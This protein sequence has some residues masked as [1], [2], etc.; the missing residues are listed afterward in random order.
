[1]HDITGD[2]AVYSKG[3]VYEQPGKGLQFPMVLTAFDGEDHEA[4]DR[5]GYRGRYVLF[6]V[7]EGGVQDSFTDPYN[8]DFGMMNA[9]LKEFCLEVRQGWRTYGKEGVGWNEL[10]DGDVITS[11][12]FHEMVNG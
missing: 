9:N 1:M 3:I 4:F 8:A 7:V 11:E 10:E 5:A 2:E 6:T 12:D